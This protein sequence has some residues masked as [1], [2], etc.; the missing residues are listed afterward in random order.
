MRTSKSKPACLLSLLL[1]AG[2]TAA[3]AG[4]APGGGMPGGQMGVRLHS[5]IE[6]RSYVFE[7]TGERLEYALFVPRRVRRSTEPAPLIVALHGL[8]TPPAMLVNDLADTAD[9]R[10]YIVVGPS[11]YRPNAMYGYGRPSFGEVDFS[12]QDVLNVLEIVRK[13]YNIDEN[14]IYL[15]GMSMGGTGALHLGRKYPDKWAAV[16]ALAPLVPDSGVGFEVMSHIPLMIMIGDRDELLPIE[17]MRDSLERLRDSGVTV[18]YFEIRGGGH[19]APIRNG[20]REVFRFF[21][22]HKSRVM[23]S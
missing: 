8:N 12:E 9:R 7:P 16:A 22:K 14:R 15:T 4:Q 23:G 19:V 11:G 17:D 20:P 3:P 5:G 18:E 6:T 21:E 1:L 13:E 2:I 10:G